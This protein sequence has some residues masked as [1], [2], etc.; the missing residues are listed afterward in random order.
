M[1]TRTSQIPSGFT[2]IEVVITLC[3]F[4]LLAAAVFSI[5][6][7]TLESAAGLQD[8]QARN[9][10]VQSLGA[11]LKRSLLD[12]PA[13]GTVVSYHRDDMPFHVAGLVWGVG[14]DLQALDLHLQ[15]NG[16][17][18]LR[19]AAYQ[20][21]SS[22]SYQVSGL[23]DTLALPQFVNEVERDDSA[24]A[25][26]TLVRDLKAAD[27]RFLPFNTNEWLDASLGQKPAI[28]E[29]TF[30]QAGAPAPVTEDFWIPPTQS[31]RILAI[32]TTPAVSSNP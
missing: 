12:M 2:L 32:P 24:L 5:F 1:R 14:N 11:W 13:S 9:D 23:T 25:W 20:P 22:P 28:V 29:L 3:V 7:A 21:S 4:V 18:T 19:L 31:P 27:W 17:Y 6:S 30:Q 15:A 8:N 16:E 10:E 26:R